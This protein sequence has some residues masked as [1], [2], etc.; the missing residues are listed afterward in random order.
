MTFEIFEVFDMPSDQAV[1]AYMKERL[2]NDPIRILG[3]FKLSVGLGPGHQTQIQNLYFG[4]KNTIVNGKQMRIGSAIF[5]KSVPGYIAHT[6]DLTFVRCVV[7]PM[8]TYNDVHRGD[9]LQRIAAGSA[10]F[11][12]TVRQTGCSVIILDWGGGQY[13]MVHLSPYDNSQVSAYHKYLYPKRSPRGGRLR[14]GWLRAELTEIAN[15]SRQTQPGYLYGTV[16]INPLRYILVQSSISYL[17]SHIQVLGVNQNGQW[18][19]FMQTGQ[20]G[21]LNAVALDWHDWSSYSYY[22]PAIV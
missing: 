21:A 3:E 2:M 6:N 7:T 16:S 10:D 12:V 20:V 11:W 5:A 8:R 22:Q 17:T 18:N 13:S 14:A 15:A 9:A 4:A 1:C 19:F